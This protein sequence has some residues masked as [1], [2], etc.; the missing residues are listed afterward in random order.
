MARDPHR[1]PPASVTQSGVHRA[2]EEAVV[3][4]SE[5]SEQIRAWSHD[6]AARTCRELLSQYQMDCVNNGPICG[7]WEAI[8]K[9][10][11]EVKLMDKEMSEG[12]G[13]A[14]AQA[15]NVTLIV[16]VVGVLSL[17]AQVFG[18]MVRLKHP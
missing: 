12:R 18:I 16:A 10:R 7:V 17:A 13:V 8:D 2:I 6:E 15:R 5:S 11:D 1:T 4:T 9:I 3:K 14:K